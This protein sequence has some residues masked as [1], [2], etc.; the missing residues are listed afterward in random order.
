MRS[1]EFSVYILSSRWRTTLYTGV[2]NDLERR[3]REHCSGDVPGF[4]KRYN[5]KTLVYA[6]SFTDIREAIAREK[7][8]KGWRRQKKIA[9][10]E[11]SNPEWR[12]LGKEWFDG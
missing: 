9:L 8:I 4:T 7:E 6:E 2:T 1:F 3:Y 10:I 11:S 5:V 12:D